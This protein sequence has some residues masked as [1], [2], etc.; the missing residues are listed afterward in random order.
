MPRTVNSDLSVSPKS[1]GGVG[2]SRL[3]SYV[4]FWS[5]TG[6]VKRQ[7]SR[8]P[9]PA[10]GLPLPAPPSQLTFS[11]EVAWARKTPLLAASAG[12]R[13]DARFVDSVASRGNGADRR[14][15]NLEVW[16]VLADCLDPDRGLGPH[17]PRWLVGRRTAG[18]GP[19]GSGAVDTM[20][21]RCPGGAFAR[22]TLC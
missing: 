16:D 14:D 2:F 12:T 15:R 11:Q 13:E 22:A 3:A 9:H 20:G 1:D 8:L 21:R 18:A 10:S 17:G 19:L 7:S 6:N 4:H 5:C